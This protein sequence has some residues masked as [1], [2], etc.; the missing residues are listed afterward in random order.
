[1]T[2]TLN[3]LCYDCKHFDPIGGGCKA[4]PD[5]IPD[6]IIESNKHFEP[7]KDQENK[8]VFEPKN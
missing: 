3:L 6:E 5:G 8:I 4:F 2:D 1:M 7:L